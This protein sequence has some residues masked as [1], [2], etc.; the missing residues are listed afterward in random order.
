MVTEWKPNINDK[1]H[2]ET[3]TRD[4]TVDGLMLRDDG[5]RYNPFRWLHSFPVSFFSRPQ[6]VPET[7]DVEG[8]EEPIGMTLAETPRSGDM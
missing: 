1:G 2:L 5:L 3:V 7:W 6:D 8:S 4:V